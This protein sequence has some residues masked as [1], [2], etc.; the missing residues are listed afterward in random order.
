MLKFI[1]NISLPEVS[2]KEYRS[3]LTVDNHTYNQ[4][5]NLGQVVQVFKKKK[6]SKAV[7]LFLSCKKGSLMLLKFRGWCKCDND[8]P[9]DYRSGSQKGR[10]GGSN[11]FPSPI[12]LPRQSMCIIGLEASSK[13]LGIASFVSK[14][15]Q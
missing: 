9:T 4:T 7:F 12:H 13:S 1:T 11:S 6:W 5:Y 10:L 3:Q 14:A 2:L 15:L 8:I